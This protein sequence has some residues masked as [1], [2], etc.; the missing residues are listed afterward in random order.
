MARSWAGQGPA[1][2]I[3][4]QRREHPSFVLLARREETPILTRGRSPLA[5]MGVRLRLPV[6]QAGEQMVATLDRDHALTTSLRQYETNSKVA[7]NVALGDGM[8]AG[9]A[10]A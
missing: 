4:L 9:L 3:P 5:A 6:R 8:G 1:N 10:R 7:L 2:P